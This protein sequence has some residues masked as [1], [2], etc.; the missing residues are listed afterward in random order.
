MMIASA[1]CMGRFSWVRASNL[2][3]LYNPRC[4]DYGMNRRHKVELFEVIRRGYAA[5]EEIQGLFS[6]LRLRAIR[7]NQALLNVR[8]GLAQSL[9]CYHRNVVGQLL[10]RVCD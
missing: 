1:N 6:H 2:A 10:S 7:A 4:N 3:H 9:S 8:P 5:G